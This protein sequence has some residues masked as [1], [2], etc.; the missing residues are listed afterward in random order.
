MK[1]MNVIP[2]PFAPTLKAR[3]FVAVKVGFPGM[4]LTALVCF[5]F[6]IICMMLFC[7]AFD[8]ILRKSHVKIL[9]GESSLR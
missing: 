4:V 3:M 1:Q 9:S 8:S 7:Y 5:L 2:T 6:S